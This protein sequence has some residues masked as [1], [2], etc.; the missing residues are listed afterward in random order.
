[1]TVNPAAE[2]CW[3]QRDPATG[4]SLDN[5]V[6][7]SASTDTA[8]AIRDYDNGLWHHLVLTTRPDGQKGYDQYLDGV[9][10]AASPYVEGVG[11]DKGYGKGNSKN[12]GK[13][14][15]KG[16]DVVTK[17]RTELSELRNEVAELRAQVACPT[18]LMRD[19]LTIV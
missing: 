10:R 6:K 13:D 11:K 12:K 14:K 8:S 2:A 1:M 4:E 7:T 16:E 17:L 15:G 5:A 19:N 18:Q 3:R 9:L